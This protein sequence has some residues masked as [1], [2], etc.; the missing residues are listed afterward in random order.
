MAQRSNTGRINIK[1]SLGAR[2][3][4]T[5][6][7]IPE[8]RKTNRVTY[9]P[10]VQLKTYDSTFPGSS[11]LGR[12]T[13]SLYSVGNDPGR[14]KVLPPNIQEFLHFLEEKKVND[15]IMEYMFSLRNENV[16]DTLRR[17]QRL[18]NKPPAH[19]PSFFD[20]DLDS[21]RK[22]RRSHKDYSGHP[23]DVWM[24]RL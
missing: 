1:S 14:K 22:K 24:Y 18:K 4:T 19:P 20:E 11:L 10:E 13:Y 6:N 7:P 8:I 9:S 17:T 12:K 15:D 2:K 5:M 23:M 21:Y 16:G 3:T